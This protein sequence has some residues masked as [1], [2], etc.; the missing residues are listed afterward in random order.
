[1]SGHG[2]DRA[3][4]RCTVRSNDLLRW[5][6]GLSFLA[7]LGASGCDSEDEC[8]IEPID[9]GGDAAAGDAIGVEVGTSGGV[10]GL[11]FIPLEDG[12]D[13]PLDT[14]G[15]GGTHATVAVRALGL[16]T[17]IAFFDVTV[18]NAETRA[19]VMTV[20]S[21]RPQL[22]ICDEAR[23]VCEQTSVHIMTGGLAP[24]GIENRDGL[25]VIV[26][27]QVRDERGRR[28]NGSAEGVLRWVGPP[29]RDAG[30]GGAD[31]DAGE[32]DLDGGG[33]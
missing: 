10:G 22:W 16:G 2:T 5:C 28:G 8:G 13:I 32:D 9:G 4:S 6:L 33:P 27:A 23:E 17:N 20:P 3:I 21:S 29:P 11:E 30:G 1:M 7:V 24:P 14:F 15:Q 31:Q 18:E 26:H 19:V 12:G 25:E